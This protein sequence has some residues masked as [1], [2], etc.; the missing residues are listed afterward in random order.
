MK[1]FS[2]SKFHNKTFYNSKTVLKNNEENKKECSK[3]EKTLKVL[4]PAAVILATVAG[5]SYFTH[6]KASSKKVESEI[7]ESLPYVE[8]LSKSLSKWLKKD[9]ESKN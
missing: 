3:T 9:V 2:V 6:N 1:V 7:K 8:E 5:V 4:V